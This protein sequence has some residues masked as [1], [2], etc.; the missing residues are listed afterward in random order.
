[1]QMSKRAIINPNM[2]AFRPLVSLALS[3][4]LQNLPCF[5]GFQ[6]SEMYRQVNG[7]KP[8]FTIYS[9]I[10]FNLAFYL[11]VVVSTQC[12]SLFDCEIRF[13]SLHAKKYMAPGK[14]FFVFSSHTKRNSLRV[15]KNKPRL[16]ESQIY[17]AISLYINFVI[18]PYIP[19]IYNTRFPY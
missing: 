12:N 10:H 17:S 7:R 5:P 9:K 18:Y 19:P 13:P 16:H 11:S 6:P 8:T 1:M 14:F 3:F 15:K 2:V 4:W